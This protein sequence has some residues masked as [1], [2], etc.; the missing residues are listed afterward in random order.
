MVKSESIRKEIEAAE[1]AKAETRGKLE[2]LQAKL[3]EATIA[4]GDK[5]LSEP[6]T[7][8]KE[9]EKLSAEIERLGYM[10][11]GY[12]RRLEKLRADLVSA[13]E[14]EKQAEIDRLKREAEPLVR[15]VL[16]QIYALYENSG[17]L[18]KLLDAYRG[19]T[20]DFRSRVI[21]LGIPVEAVRGITEN[22][23]NAAQDGAPR[24]K[25]MMLEEKIPDRA[26]RAK[27]GYK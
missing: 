2:K 20:L 5:L 27:A 19:I 17:E 21:S 23:L 18:V 1:R 26:E 6:D 9:L 12:D 7:S 3:D 11:Q 4:L 15:E 24:L 22:W 16:K 13:K 25:E 8:T 10:T 14:A